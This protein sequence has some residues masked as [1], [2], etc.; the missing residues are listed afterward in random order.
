MARTVINGIPHHV[1]QRGNRK[2]DV[3]FQKSDYEEYL[4][5]IK[6]YSELYGVEIWNYCLIPNHVHL[7]AVPENEASLRQVFSEVHRRYTRM[8][9]FR[10]DWKGCLWQ[11]R[12]YSYPMDEPHAL[13]AARY[14]ELNPVSHGLVRHFLDYEYSSAKSSI[15]IDQP[16]FNNINPLLHFVDDWKKFILEKETDPEFIKKILLHTKTGRPLGSPDF[17]EQMEAITGRKLLPNK[18]G[19]KSKT[20]FSGDTVRNVLRTVSP[21]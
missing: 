1:T 18:P 19:R 13:E 16:K 9:N 14:I 20:I 5:L 10:N 6:K 4:H 8:I 7:I 12:F 21:E 17:I 2:Q 3:F 11:G 15:G